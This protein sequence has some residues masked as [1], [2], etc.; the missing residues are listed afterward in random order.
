MTLSRLVPSVLLSVSLGLFAADA[1]ADSN[2]CGNI[3]FTS[4]SECH[5]EASGGC[6]AECTPLKLVASCDGQCNASLSASCTGSCQADCE[7]DCNV[8]PAQFSCQASCES[9]CQ[10]NITARC[11]GEADQA[12][13]QS[14]CDA[15]CQSDCQGQ[16][17]VVPPSADCKAKC[18][19]SC[20]GKC[21]TDANFDCSYKCSADLQGGCKVACEE[22][23]GAL[24]C[25]GQFINVTS[26][27]ACADYLLS[28]YNYSFK[29]ETSGTVSLD[30]SSC[31]IDPGPSAPAGGLLAAFGAI[32]TGLVARRRMRREG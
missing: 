29:V 27:P 26:I 23:S 9:S 11:Q 15:M 21:E 25:N 1:S 4:I 5:L 24:F 20:S 30:G 31:A 18:Q 28:H 22:P 2:P 13:C 10:A 3:E 19:G 14:Y 12:G 16:C 17:N 6:E 32:V 8:Q 7:A